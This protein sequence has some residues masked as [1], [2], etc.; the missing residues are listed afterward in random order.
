[1][2]LR[3]LQ[4]AAEDLQIRLEEH[5]RRKHEADW[6]KEQTVKA[7]KAGDKG[8]RLQNNTVS[9]LFQLLDNNKDG[10]HADC[11]YKRL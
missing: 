7:L 8:L 6:L 9:H 10:R 5:R 2:Q 4:R 11:L 1:A 3:E